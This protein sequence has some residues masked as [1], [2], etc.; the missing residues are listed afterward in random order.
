MPHVHWSLD[1]LSSPYWWRYTFAEWLHGKKHSP[2]SV[3]KCISKFSWSQFETSPVRVKQ[4]DWV[5]EHM[6]EIKK[7][8][9]HK[10]DSTFGKYPVDLAYECC[11]KIDMKKSFKEKCIYSLE[12]VHHSAHWVI[13]DPADPSKP[14]WPKQ[15]SPQRSPVVQK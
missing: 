1:H 3:K 6:G 7:G 8:I 4:I 11:I 12:R 9:L 15:R 13:V 14:T 10:K 5:P 2:R